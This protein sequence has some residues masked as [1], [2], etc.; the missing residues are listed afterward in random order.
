MGGNIKFRPTNP[1]K[2][3]GRL[4]RYSCVVSS[5]VGFFPA[6]ARAGSAGMTKKMM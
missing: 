6:T 1:G 2:N 3:R 4:A 5:G